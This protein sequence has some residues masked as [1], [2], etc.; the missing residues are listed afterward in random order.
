MEI[1]TD[2]LIPE[3]S[4]V[5][6]DADRMYRELFPDRKISDEALNEIMDDLRSRFSVL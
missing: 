1:L 5:R 6:D 3:E 2:F 4:A